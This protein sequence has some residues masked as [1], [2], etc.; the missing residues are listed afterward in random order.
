MSL[1]EITYRENPNYPKLMRFN[2]PLG[3]TISKMPFEGKLTPT[4]KTYEEFEFYYHGILAGLQVIHKYYFED[5]ANTIEKLI[6]KFA[7][8]GT[9]LKPF[10]RSVSIGSGF[11]SRRVI[12]WKRESIYLIINEI[13]RHTNKGRNPII[14]PDLFAFVWLKI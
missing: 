10:Y 9:E 11:K 3:L 8:P 13:S 2:N 6:N 4:Q 7:K 14:H 12:P 1:Q 5:K